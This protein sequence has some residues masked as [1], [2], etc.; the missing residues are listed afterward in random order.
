MK[1]FTA[2]KEGSLHEF[3]IVWLQKHQ[4]Y[5]TYTY[6]LC[7]YNF[8]FGIFN[9]IMTDP[10]KHHIFLKRTLFLRKIENE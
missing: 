1:D 3:V 10:H 2:E 4:K 6:K 9:K 8:T 5:N 7:V